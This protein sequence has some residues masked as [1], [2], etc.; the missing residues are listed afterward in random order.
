LPNDSNIPVGTRHNIY[1]LSPTASTVLQA[2]A[3]VTLNW[4]GTLTGGAAGAAGGAAAA[5]TISGVYQKV[6]LVKTGS[7]TWAA[8]A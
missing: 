8:F 3:G 6:T 4:N 7:T 5:L 1:D 2:A